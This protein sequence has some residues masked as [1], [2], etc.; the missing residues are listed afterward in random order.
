MNMNIDELIPVNAFLTPAQIKKKVGEQCR[1]LRSVHFRWSR[2]R[3]AEKSGVSRATIQRFEAG[4]DI[5]LSNLVSLAQAMSTSDRFVTLFELPEVSS[6]A[7]LEKRRAALN[8][9]ERTKARRR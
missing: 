6:I 2:D 5:S 8:R 4:G 9:I 3:L 1:I 7:E